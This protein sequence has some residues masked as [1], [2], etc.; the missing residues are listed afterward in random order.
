MKQLF[1]SP[2]NIIV[3]LL[4][5]I[6]F[7]TKEVK[8]DSIRII[9]IEEDDNTEDICVSCPIGTYSNKDD[10]LSNCTHYCEDGYCP[11]NRTDEW[12]LQCRPGSYS[13]VYNATDCI[14]C[15]PGYISAFPG[16]SNC[17]IC[18]PGSV[19]NSY[20]SL[21]LLCPA[22]SKSNNSGSAYCIDC[23]PG[24]FSNDGSLSCTNCEPGS[25]NPFTGSPQCIPC[26]RGK[27]NPERGSYSKGDCLT[28]PDGYYCPSATNSEPKICPQDKYCKGGAS[29]PVDCPDLF[30][31]DPASVNCT[32]R[33]SLYVI[34]GVGC[35][36]I[37][38]LFFGLI[39][40]KTRQA[41]IAVNLSTQKKQNE[42]DR[43]IPPS[44]GGPVYEGL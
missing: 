25:Y 18:P 5:V 21:C 23:L 40:Y 24:Q 37:V 14:D 8:S 2:L 20:S 26:G 33:T 16:Q 12:C 35:V 38:T 42:N 41:Q 4:V 44:Q 10:P 28:C 9:N 11:K 30:Q 39:W 19:N 3:V 13:D 36:I 15:A 32:P 34:V 31:S 43:L 27:W 7:I 22:G 29:T 17:S 6:P 1:S